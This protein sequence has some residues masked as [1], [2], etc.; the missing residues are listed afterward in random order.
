VCHT[1][2]VW[3]SCVRVG[4]NVSGSARV[5]HPASAQGRRTPL[6]KTGGEFIGAGID[7]SLRS[8][9]QCYLKEQTPF[10]L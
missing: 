1:F 2:E 9:G 8:E 10:A 6:L 4:L 3:H 7:S 5:D